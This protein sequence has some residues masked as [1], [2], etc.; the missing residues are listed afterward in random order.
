MRCAQRCK[1]TKQAEYIDYLRKALRAFPD[2]KQGV[3]ILLEELK[4]SNTQDEFECY[5]IEVKQKIQELI[6]SG[7]MDDAKGILNEYKSIVPNDIET[8]LL[9]SRILLQ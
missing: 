6:D 2:M 3:E 5:K 4:Q 9:E 8:I 7:K 1:D